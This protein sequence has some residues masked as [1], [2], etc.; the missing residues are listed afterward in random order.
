MAA[1]ARGRRRREGGGAARGRADRRGGRCRGGRARPL[2]DGDERRPL[3][4]GDA[5][6]PRRTR[7]DALGGDRAVPGRRADRLARQRGP[8]P[9]PHGAR[10]LDGPPGDAAADAGHPARPRGRRPRLRERRCRSASTSSTSASA[11][12][13]TPPRWSPA[14]R[15]SRSSD[16]RVAL[17]GGEYQGHRRM[18]L[19]YPAID[20]AR[21]ILW[22]VTGAEKR[23][24]LAK[25]LAGDAL[26][27]GRPGAEREHGRRRRRGGG[28]VE[29]SSLLAN[30]L[31]CIYGRA[32][33]PAVPQI[34][35]FADRRDSAPKRPQS[36]RVGA[37][38]RHPALGSQR[39]P[40]REP[41]AGSR[42]SVADCRRRGHRASAP[43]RASRRSTRKSES[44][45]RA[46]SRAGGGAAVSSAGGAA[47]SAS[48]G[49][50]GQAGGGR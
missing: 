11:P 14:T 26:D 8:Q 17:T 21:Q 28:A 13:A 9:H 23:E 10:P 2:R 32:P 36:G 27:P 29:K 5:G 47:V 46:G 20:A 40:P 3:P 30:S 12:T 33:V 6:D 18:T 45:T 48:G 24:P 35:G 49:A 1:Q 37:T 25:L 41:G 4:L 19:T 22:L 39:L 7:A 16:R 50:V 44:H 38:R 15:C 42:R 31:T 43:S 34:D